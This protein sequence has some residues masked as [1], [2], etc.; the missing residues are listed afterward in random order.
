[1][2]IYLK[3]V[4][5]FLSFLNCDLTRIHYR[6]WE[7]RQCVQCYTLHQQWEQFLDFYQFLFFPLCK[8]WT[9]LLDNIS[10]TYRHI[11]VCWCRPL[12]SLQGK[13]LPQLP[14]FSHCQHWIQSEKLSALTP[15]SRNAYTSWESV[16]GN[17][18]Q[19]SVINLP[20]LSCCD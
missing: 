14:I 2:I 5:C 17:R 3:V 1:M 13:S 4:Y 12:K 9:V 7:C 6:N 8:V 18:I 16:E 11:S 10:H 15:L 19:T 20:N